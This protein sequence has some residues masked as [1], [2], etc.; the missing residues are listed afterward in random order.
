MCDIPPPFQVVYSSSNQLFKL[1]EDQLQRGEVYK[2][3][4]EPEVSALREAVHVFTSRLDER[5]DVILFTFEWYQKIELVRR[6][7]GGKEVGVV[8]E[9]YTRSVVHVCVLLILP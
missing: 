9:I 4:I 5:R 7:E 2:A 6:E 1:V 8:Y 3:T